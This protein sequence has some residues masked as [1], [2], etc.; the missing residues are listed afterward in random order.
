MSDQYVTVS[1]AW[2][3]LTLINAGLAQSKGR[4][5]LRWWLAS[6]F[7]GPFATL[8]IVA[9]PA[10]QPGEPAPEVMG[11][12]QATIIGVAVVVL[13]VAIAGLVFARL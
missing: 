8:L 7:L 5:G 2:F 13:I 11:R 6:I 9:W 10:V 1:A 4:S 3:T 12:T